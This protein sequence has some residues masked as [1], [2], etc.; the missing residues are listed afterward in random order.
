MSF[1]SLTI[2]LLLPLLQDI[3]TVAEQTKLP[4]G[5]IPFAKDIDDVNMLVVE[6]ETGHVFE[7]CIDEGGSSVISKSFGG[8]IENYRDRLLSGRNEFIEDVGVVE[9]L[10]K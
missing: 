2:V 4:V 5:S 1:S 7:I 6:Q 3:G 8:L 10:R 9:K